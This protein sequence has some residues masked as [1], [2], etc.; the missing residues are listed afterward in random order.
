MA[1]W[2]WPLRHGVAGMH[3]CKVWLRAAVLRLGIRAA[4][5]LTIHRHLLLQSS[6]EDGAALL[7]HIIHADALLHVMHQLP[8]E[9]AEVLRSPDV[10]RH[11]FSQD[12]L[13]QDRVGQPVLP[14]RC[15]PTPGQCSALL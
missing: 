11:R 9:A 4:L 7:L 14:A 1:V 10:P 2:A 8:Q 15:R 12:V 13:R 5:M 3:R 6:Q